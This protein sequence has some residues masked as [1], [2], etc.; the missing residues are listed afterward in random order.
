MPLRPMLIITGLI[1]ALLMLLFIS[2]LQGA[3]DISVAEVYTSLQQVISQQTDGSFATDVVIEMRLPRAML[4]ILVGGLLGLAGTLVQAL[5]R[6]PMADPYLLGVSNGAALA[7]VLVVV[8]SA[9]AL[10][11]PMLLQTSACVGGFVA[12]A[13]VIILTYNRNS[14]LNTNQLILGGIAISF[15]LSA[16]TSLLMIRA[17][18]HLLPGIMQW[19]MGSMVDANWPSLLPLTI[20]L[21]IALGISCYFHRYLDA[22]LLGDDKA[23]TLGINLNRHKLM[24]AVLVAILTGVAVSQAGVV[25]FIGLMVPHFARFLVGGAHQY[26][27]PIATLLGMV[28]CVSVDMLCRTLIAP[29]ELPIGIPMALIAMPFFIILVRSRYAN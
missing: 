16:L 17:D 9:G 1:V 29:E 3:I 19:M 7:V 18:S 2:L 5:V 22:L 27:L 23:I 25:G 8:T 24:W 15:M 11:H 20:I 14:P 10:V 13:L 21:A 4:A 6:N 28:L 12:F 26:L